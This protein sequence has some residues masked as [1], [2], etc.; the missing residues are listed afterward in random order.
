MHLSSLCRSS[1]DLKTSWFVHLVGNGT[2]LCHI[3]N[4]NDNYQ[5]L[6]NFHKIE[7]LTFWGAMWWQIENMW[8]KL[9]SKVPLQFTQPNPG[10]TCVPVWIFLT[11][12]VEIITEGQGS[13][14]H[15]LHT[16]RGKDGGVLPDTEWLET[17]SRHRQLLPE[18]WPILQRIHENLGRPQKAGTALQQI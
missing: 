8:P 4:W 9:F 6:N 14:V 18:S 12:Q 5:C 10:F 16:G 7:T 15:V 3:K 13:A 1:G 2:P 17:R 11:A